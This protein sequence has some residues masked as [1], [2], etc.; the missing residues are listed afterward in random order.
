MRASL[1]PCR[2]VPP[3]RTMPALARCPSHH[4]TTMGCPRPRS[5]S[6]AVRTHSTGA[7]ASSGASPRPGASIAAVRGRARVTTEGEHRTWGVRRGD[8]HT[9][10]AVSH[11][12]LWAPRPETQCGPVMTEIAQSRKPAMKHEREKMRDAREQ[13]PN[14]LAALSGGG[15]GARLSRNAHMFG[16]DDENDELFYNDRA[17]RRSTVRSWRLATR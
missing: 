5:P 12:Q 9:H 7:G 17:R 10:P 15:R 3:C 2:P 14:V 13:M 6:T 4:G 1:S 8:R 16:E 11:R